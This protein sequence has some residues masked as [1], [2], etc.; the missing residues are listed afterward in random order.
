MN[1]RYSPLALLPLF[2][3][4]YGYAQS[5]TADTQ[6]LMRDYKLKEADIVLCQKQSKVAAAV[7]QCLQQTKVME[8]IEVKGRY[9]GPELPEIVG[10][11]HLDRNFIQRSPKSTGDINELIALMPGVQL[12]ESAYALNQAAEIQAKELSISGGQ[13]WQTGFFLD[14]VNYNSRLDPSGSS[15][16]LYEAND[17]R[18]SAQA[19]TLN[20]QLVESIDV[21]DSNIPANFGDFSGG[22]VD[23]KSRSAFDQNRFGISYRGTQ[24]DWGNYKLIT[25]DNDSASPASTGD[26]PVYEKNSYGVS[27]SHQFNSQHALLIN[28]NYL[29]STVSELSLGEMV[30]T[31]RENTNLLLKYSQRD[32]WL[33]R[34]DLTATYAPYKNHNIQTNVK[35]SEFV[36]E[37]G[38]F[39]TALNLAEDLRLG[40]W[41]GKLSYSGSENSRDA[42][43]HYYVWLQAKGKD[44]GKLDQVQNSS[45]T[46]VSK[47]GGLG[48]LD[49]TQNN[50]R[51]ESSLQ[52]NDMNYLGLNHRLLLGIDIESEQIK[53]QRFYD[54]YNY[55]AA[56]Q[57]SSTQTP[58]NCNGYL[59]DCVELA[60]VRPLAE[61]EQEL[62]RPLDLSLVDDM[63]LYSEN[64]SSTP[65]Y[66][67]SRLVYP[68]ELIDE[69]V[70]KNALYLTDQIESGDWDW[71]LGLRYSTDNFFKN[72][73]LAPRLS[74]G[75]RLFGDADSLLT[76][77]LNRYYDA[78]LLSYKIKEAQLPYYVQYRPIRNGVLQGWLRSSADSDTRV[79]YDNVKTP[80]D[81][82]ATLGFKQNTEHFGTFSIKAVKRWKKDQL[83]AAS[84]PVRESDG[85]FYKYQSN[86]GSGYSNR[87]SLAWS[88]QWHDHSF[89]LNTSFSKTFSSTNE[90]DENINNTAADELVILDGQ[91]TSLDA[92]NRINTNFA[93]PLVLNFGWSSDWTD[94]LNSSLTATYKASY[95]AAADTGTYDTTGNTNW[96]CPE[97]S[98]GS[99]LVPVYS[100]KR[101]DGTTLV[102]LAVNYQLYQSATGNLALSADITNLFDSRTHQI[103]PG[104]NGVE[105][106]RQFWI[107]ISYDYY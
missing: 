16:A 73:N 1:Y 102:N 19:F 6:Q 100:T 12:S 23:V 77:G 72:Q 94:N 2:A 79:R 60:F 38:G 90:F 11:Y 65:Q 24:S 93:R 81:D 44:W 15:G 80:Y 39:S 3:S 96:L 101:L 95:T 89:W 70:L 40:Q 10:R 74:A 49:K 33:D 54:S 27:A 7:H 57:Y 55:T 45:V 5:S 32:L 47:Q 91:L 71:H 43:D 53:R 22:V 30:A 17:V 58:L 14:G 62:G 82:E 36:V 64:V 86:S 76:F 84:D 20:S 87:L 59:Y 78:G 37:G 52:F 98:S 4:C 34:V 51:L 29:E 75:Y 66:F 26:A 69:K 67:E 35:D 25:G 68:S 103:L 42:A 63:L 9:T 8:K 56:R 18:G 105:I 106:G 88:K 97:C 21:Y 48:D 104:A 28:L 46:P 50:A 99:V 85:Y 92:L 31:Q 83:A 13:P 61:L 41:S 107:G